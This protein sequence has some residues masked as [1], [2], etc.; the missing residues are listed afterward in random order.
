MADVRLAAP[1]SAYGGT[2]PYIFVSYAHADGEK[3]FPEITFLHEQGYR[4]WYDEGIDPGNEWPDEIARALEV[5]EY[6]LVFISPSAV[7]SINVR[8][9]INAA[10]NKH[11]PF[12][13]VHL[14]ETQLSPG[15][16]LRMG[17]IQALM[18]FRMETGN[19]RKRLL[20]VLPT[21]V[22]GDTLA[23]SPTAAQP[24]EAA[25][26]DPDAYS[27]CLGI[28]VVDSAG[29][30]TLLPE[31]GIVYNPFA[32]K[33]LN[34]AARDGLILER[35]SATQTLPWGSISRIVIRGEDAASVELRVGRSIGPVIPRSGL[36]VGTDELGFDFSL[37]LSHVETINLAMET[38]VP[39]WE[40]LLRDIPELV[41]KKS[42]GGWTAAVALV[43]QQHGVLVTLDSFLDGQRHSSQ[44]FELPGPY[45]F[46]AVK[47]GSRCFVA[48]HAKENYNLG[49]YDCETG[50]SLAKALTRL[51]VLSSKR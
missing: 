22:K 49:P 51:N 45:D 29:T 6:F 33:R 9:E 4:I 12:L 26:P 37:S 34:N 10:L 14:V 36:L 20:K 50:T 25:A 39:E 16:E 41:R 1:I 13:A 31:F 11:K 48:V 2:A 30:R 46:C 24:A 8:N 19:Y 23:S 42:P 21:S 44:M 28:S 43:P 32:D 18:R 47:D 15:L 38:G 7:K 17:D 27:K 5:A 3:V 35:G 40:A